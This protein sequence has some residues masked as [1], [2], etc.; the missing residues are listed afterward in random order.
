[1]KI[2]K[3]KS[4]S[5]YMPTPPPTTGSVA[6]VIANKFIP[7]QISSLQSELRI[8]ASVMETTENYAPWQQ[9]YGKHFRFSLLLA[10]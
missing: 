5:E 9:A 1:M 2:L 6:T 3:L 4:W 10:V 8:Q 7:W